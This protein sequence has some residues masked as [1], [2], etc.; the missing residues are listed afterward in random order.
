MTFLTKL[1]GYASEDQQTPPLNREGMG[2]SS[3]N[4]I[5]TL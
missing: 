2:K 4:Y 1:V 3:N 5:D